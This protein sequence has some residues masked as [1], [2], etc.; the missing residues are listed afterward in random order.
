M[1]RTTQHSDLQQPDRLR[2]TGSGRIGLI[3]AASMAAGLVG[4]VALVAAPFIPAK[5]NVLT[6]VV[7][8]A[9]AFGWALLAVLSMRFSDQ[10]Q[11]WAAAPAVFL[12]VAG[13][14][15]L[16]PPDSVVQDV[17]GWVWPP[18][19]LGLVVWMVVRARRQLRSR[20]RRWLVYPLLAVLALASIGGGNQTVWESIEASAYPAPG[21]LIDVG[22][23]RLHLSCTGSDSPTV[24]LEPGMGEASWAMGWIAPAVARDSRVCVY[25][26]AGRGW[27]DPAHGP[28][29][30]VQTVT[31]LHTLLDRAHIP[32]PHG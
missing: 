7:L 12:A 31:D 3:V 8:L 20:T 23:H 13:L 11:R 18:L 14:I 22:G 15:S 26:R 19:L 6:G 30:A 21:Q 16:L 24:I 10:P 1:A 4:A 28:Q 5:E 29:D 17:F 2:P 32:G 27:S 25:D 9:F